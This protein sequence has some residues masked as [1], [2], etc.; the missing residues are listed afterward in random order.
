MSKLRVWKV[1]SDIPIEEKG[2][3]WEIKATTE[4]S[5]KIK[6]C[7][8]LRQF[9][10]TGTVTVISE[11]TDSISD[12]ILTEYELSLLQRDNKYLMKQEEKMP[13]YSWIM[14]GTGVPEIHPFYK[15]TLKTYKDK[16]YLIQ[17]KYRFT[18][19]ETVLNFLQI[20]HSE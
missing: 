3:V 12:R 16:I 1:I 7:L 8:I 15:T 6:G 11:I 4:E 5:A 18:V 10:D 13:N 9:S 2:I 17:G 14:I 19:T 20:N